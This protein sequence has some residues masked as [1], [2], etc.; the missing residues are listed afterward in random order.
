MLLILVI[1]CRIFLDPSPLSVTYFM[2]GPL[3]MNN[4]SLLHVQVNSIVKTNT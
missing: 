4:C 1:N 2:D 3:G